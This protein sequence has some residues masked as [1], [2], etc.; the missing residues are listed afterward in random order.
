MVDGFG[1]KDR[2]TLGGTTGNVSWLR[3][4]PEVVHATIGG[5]NEKDAGLSLDAD[6]RSV[7]VFDTAQVS[8]QQ[9]PIYQWMPQDSLNSGNNPAT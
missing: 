4:S 7:R 9:K 2:E 3:V 6:V 8:A 5:S 1:Q